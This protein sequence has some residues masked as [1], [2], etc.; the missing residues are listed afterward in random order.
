MKKKVL[1]KMNLVADVV[2]RRFFPFTL[3]NFEEADILELKIRSFFS[4]S[5]GKWQNK[6]DYLPFS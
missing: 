6:L 3:R 5:L 4:S 2:L 1:Y